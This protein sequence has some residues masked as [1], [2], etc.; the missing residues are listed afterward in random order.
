[1]NLANEDYT[2]Q[3]KSKHLIQDIAKPL[4]MFLLSLTKAQARAIPVSLFTNNEFNPPMFS[5][6]YFHPF[7][8]PCLVFMITYHPN[9]SFRVCWSHFMLKNVF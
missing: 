9:S 8:I 7:H 3:P 2:K 5:Y 4:R 1:M 6:I